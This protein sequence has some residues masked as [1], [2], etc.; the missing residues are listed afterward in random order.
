MKKRIAA[1]M[2][3]V[4]MAFGLTA[5]G[6]GSASGT[7]SQSG[8][9]GQAGTS[10]KTDGEVKE[11]TFWYQDNKLMVPYVQQRVDEFNKD[12]EG[13]YHLSVEFIP[14]GSAYAYEDKVNAAASAGILPDILSMDGVNVSN[15][16][17]NG[18]VVPITKYIT[19]ESRNDMMPSM[20]IQN[21]YENEMYA[22]GL[23]EATC[24]FFYN[25]D[26]FEANGFRIPTSMEDAYTW[27]EVYDMAKQVGTPEMAGV[28]IIMDKGEGIIY[29][30]S[31]FW[32]SAGAPLV[33]EDGSACTGYINSEKS[34]ETAAY[35]QKFFTEKLANIDPTPTEFQD[36]K[37]AMWISANISQVSGF[38]KDYPDFKWGATYLPR[39]DSGEVSAPCG[40]WAAGITKNC[41]DPDGAFLALD[42][43]TNKDAARFYS[44]NAGYPSARQSSYENNEKWSSYPYN[45]AAEQLFKAAVPRPK[46]PIYTVLSPKFSETMLDIFTGSDPKESLDSLAEYVDAEYVRF[47]NSLGK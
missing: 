23:N 3:A 46:T 28:K 29:G 22:I 1:A 7:D 21:T 15:Y 31:P 43:L 14:R 20:V 37:A 27:S 42:Y 35:L 30:L 38:E 12:Y 36:G 24:L 32:I 17:A 25:K 18:I 19:E 34:I 13:T 16:A 2:L 44:D 41:K 39:Y 47:Q 5:C 45:M 6:G 40:S 33:S 11:L 8:Q 9:A 10:G 4:V 26:V